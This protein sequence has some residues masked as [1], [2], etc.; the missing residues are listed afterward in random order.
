MDDEEYDY[1]GWYRSTRKLHA[2]DKHIPNK[3][4]AKVLRRL[5]S[6]TGQTEEQLRRCKKF[7]KLLS[8]AQKRQGNKTQDERDLIN[9]LKGV[10]R[11]LKLP[12]EHPAVLEEFKKRIQQLFDR[13]N[14]YWQKTVTIVDVKPEHIIEIY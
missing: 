8:D 1:G 3:N 10:L 14:V 11:D 12:K 9:L 13:K 5:M 7:R 2:G 4:E 6:E